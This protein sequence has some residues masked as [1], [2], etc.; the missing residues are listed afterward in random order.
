M[1]ALSSAYYLS[2]CDIQ[3]GV[4]EVIEILCSHR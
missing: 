4:K 1:I 3:V 2:F